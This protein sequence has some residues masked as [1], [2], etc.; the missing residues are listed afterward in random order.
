MAT[1]L[2]NEELSPSLHETNLEGLLGSSSSAPPSPPK[3]SKKR[4]K[5]YKSGWGSMRRRRRRWPMGPLY[6]REEEKCLCLTHSHTPLSPPHY[7]Y[8][9]F[10]VTPFFSG[11]SSAVLL[12]RKSFPLLGINLLFPFS[13]FAMRMKDQQSPREICPFPYCGPECTV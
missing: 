6:Y 3:K 8:Y 11:T 2:F 10:S 7:A 5:G 12:F 1:L 13:S 9:P 4:K